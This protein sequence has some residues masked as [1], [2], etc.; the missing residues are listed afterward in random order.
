MPRSTCGHT[1]TADPVDLEVWR[2]L[3]FDPRVTDA[4]RRDYA[5]GRLDAL[6]DS[7]HR[8]DSPGPEVRLDHHQEKTNMPNHLDSLDPDSQDVVRAQLRAHGLITVAHLPESERDEAITRL[9]ASEQPDVAR[10]AIRAVEKLERAWR[11]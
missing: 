10:A 6:R 5:L 9:D 7:G 4:R 2:Y 3:A 8:I 11:G 1:L